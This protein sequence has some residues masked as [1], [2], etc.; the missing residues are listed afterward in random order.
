MTND[1]SGND[2]FGLDAN[3]R[4]ELAFKR[5]LLVEWLE[6]K[7]IDAIVV[8]RLD[9]IAWLTAGLVDVRVGVLR[10][11]GAA[12]LLLTREG[13]AFYLAANNE[14]ERLAEEEFDGLGFEP[15]IYPW[16]ASD[17]PSRAAEKVGPGKIAGDMGQD[18]LASVSIQSLRWELTAGEAV[19]Y[20]WLGHRAAETAEEVLRGFEPGMSESAMQAALATQLI[21]RG[22]LP[23]VYL[24]AADQR[25]VLYPH[26]VPRAGILRTIGMLGFCARRWGLSVS[27]TRF[28]CF[29]PPQAEFDEH[30]GVAAEV[31]AR[32]LGST[33]SGATSNELFTAAQ[34]GYASAGSPGAELRHHQGGPTGYL[35]REWFARPGGLEQVTARQAVVWNP[36]LNGA[37]VED[38]YLLEQGKLE[39]LTAT[40]GLPSITTTVAGVGY[41]SAAP[42]RL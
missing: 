4:A 18:G 25:L 10:E 28:L 24:T 23:S 9:N 17:L 19:R 40:P 36:S 33:R 42:L 41:R 32:L 30:L 31:N 15:V 1:S 21:G 29:G 8:S 5:R 7:G 6:E 34:Q 12:S 39:L 22:I 11:S 2:P 3:R 13:G 26:P 27:M 20:R 16:T 35:E 37:K 38:T 14:A